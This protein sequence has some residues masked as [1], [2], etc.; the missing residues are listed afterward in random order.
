MEGLNDGIQYQLLSHTFTSFKLLV[1]KALIVENK[2]REI[3]NKKRKFQ[4]Q[5]S[6]RNIRVR[7]ATS[8]AYTSENSGIPMLLMH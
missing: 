7:S 5:Q 6:R 1:D 4:G 3:E 2:R 8:Q